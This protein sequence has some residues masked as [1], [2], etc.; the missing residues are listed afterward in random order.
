MEN[1]VGEAIKRAEERTLK[2]V[3]EALGTSILL[4]VAYTTINKFK[5]NLNEELEK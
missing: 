2:E 5:K 4:G 1:E 3:E